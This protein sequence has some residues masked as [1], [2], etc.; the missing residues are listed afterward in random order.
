MPEG[1]NVTATLDAPA[2]T[3]APPDLSP[4]SGE[5]V[6]EE[7]APAQ[8]YSAPAPSPAIDYDRFAA[9]QAQA[10]APVFQQ[11]APK[12]SPSAQPWDKPEFWQL[13]EGPDANRMFHERIQQFADARAKAAASEAV[14]SLRREFAQ[15]LQGRDAYMQARY[16]P[17]PNFTRIEAHFQ[18]YV[19][20]GMPAQYARRLAEQD[21]GVGGAP[22]GAG[23]ARGVPTPPPH[24][25]S[26]GTRSASP[27]QQKTKLDIWN[28]KSREDAAKAQ[29]AKLGLPWNMDE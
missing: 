26:P 10:L 13:P 8:Q 1:D 6:H 21:A 23:Q 24:L 17:D 20:E 5:Q 9:A 3:S 19:R 27:A 2:E 4:P 22:S 28:A 15:A 12:P 7:Q 29:A 18:K 25:T 11:F 16:A 14:E